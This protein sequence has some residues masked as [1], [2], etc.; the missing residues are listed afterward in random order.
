MK[1]ASPAIDRFQRPYEAPEG[2]DD[3]TFNLDK[4]QEYIGWLSG[5]NLL[6]QLELDGTSG[7]WVL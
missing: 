2:D 6:K 4:I 1:M 3:V 7:F 5:T